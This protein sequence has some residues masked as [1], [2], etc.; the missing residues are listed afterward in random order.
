MNY[1]GFL[2]KNLRLDCCFAGA[3]LGR[4]ENEKRAKAKV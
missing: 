4:L 3:D 2:F 1:P